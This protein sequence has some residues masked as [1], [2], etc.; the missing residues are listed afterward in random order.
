MTINEEDV[1]LAKLWIDTMLIKQP[2]KELETL[3]DLCERNIAKPAVLYT[4]NDGVDYTHFKSEKDCP[5]C[6]HTIKTW[7]PYCENCGQRLLIKENNNNGK[8]E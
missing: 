3:K 4:C 8:N 1:R 7:R 6:G 2:C 5:R